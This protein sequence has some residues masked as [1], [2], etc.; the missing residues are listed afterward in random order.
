MTLMAGVEKVVT[1][2]VTVV[3]VALNPP[4]MADAPSL[5]A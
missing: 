3:A 5:T 2:T 4:S 1:V